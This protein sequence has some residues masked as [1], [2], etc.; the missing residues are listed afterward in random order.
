MN[1][2]AVQ[3]DIKINDL[4]A[5]RWSAR[6]FSDTPIQE[7]EMQTLFEAARWTSSS[8]N[9]QPWQFLYA[10]KCDSAFQKFYNCLLPGNQPWC[11]GASVLVLSLAKKNF[12]GNNK[13]NRHYMHDTGAANTTLL[14]QAAELDIY[15]HML[16]GFDMQKTISEF[17]ID[18]EWE[19][20]CFI[21]LGYLGS[22]DNL[23][24]P[25]K[26]REITP[27]TRKPQQD[28]VSRLI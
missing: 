14:L 26:T 17:N 27:R 18:D 28:M 13:P 6:S 20:A 3:S 7:S 9:E 15:G 24:E 12:A 1:I 8:M 25:F 23:E 19:V 10:H 21:A 16:G 11:A 4:I 22:P 5:K 2:K